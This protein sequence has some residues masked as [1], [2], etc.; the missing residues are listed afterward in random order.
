MRNRT[1][2][3][4]GA[5]SLLLFTAACGELDDKKN[6]DGAD[7]EGIESAIPLADDYDAEGHLDWAWSNPVTHWDPV[8]SVTGGD[9]YWY[10]PVFDRLLRMEPDGTIVP[11]L[12]ETWEPSA[13]GK[14]LTMTLQEGLTFSDGTPFN[15][16]A[17]KFNL[18]RAA[19]Q[20]STIAGE[21]EQISSVEVIDAATVKINVDN[22]LGALI[23]SLAVRPG[24]MISPTA[25]QAGTTADHPVGVG[26]YIVTESIPGDQVSYEKS[27]N[28]WDADAQNT[29]TMTFYAMSDDQTRL[30]ALESG[31]VDGAYLSPNQADSAQGADL[32]V[33]SAPTSTFVYFMLNE[34]VEPYDDPKVR[35]AVNM[36]IDREGIAEGLYEGFCTPEIQP[37]PSTSFAYDEEIGD[38]SEIW[39]HDPEAAKKLMEEAGVTEPV[40]M[41]A[42]TTN[43]TQYQQLAEVLQQNFKEIGINMTIKPGPSAEGVQLYAV[44]KSA[45]GNINPYTGI[46]DPHGPIVRY[47][48]PGALYNP[49]EQTP[50]E[51]L[52]KA[53]EAATPI[54][55][56]E[57]APLYAEFMEMWVEDPP[58]MMPICFVH[59]ASAL[60][61]QVSGVAIS[62]SAGPDM[63][64]AAIAKE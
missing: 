10:N 33:I 49:G 21:V 64:Y 53:Y 48:I 19:G 35:Q 29:A 62:S 46:P 11:M 50:Q 2:L 7:S 6:S 31:Q 13:D 36:A 47:L 40:E 20:G 4:A 25:A 52:D 12:A 42:V 26:P 58:H 34:A 1:R 59:S 39:P 16:E 45:H 30:N 57:R 38:G 51:M 32:N 37:W 63:R 56:A 17:V 54:D 18:D 61:D 28:Y 55:P 27:P 60:S 22:A 5:I 9:L 14:S 8:K 44:D 43:I 24:I 3:F 15:A 23:T 41:T